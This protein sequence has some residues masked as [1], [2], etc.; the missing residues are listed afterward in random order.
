MTTEKKSDFLWTTVAGLIFVI[1]LVAGYKFK[2]TMLKNIAETAEID[3]SCDLKQG[4]CQSDLPKGGKV[5]LSITPKD[6]PIL[7]PLKLEVIVEGVDATAVAV[8]FVGIDMD[9]GYNRSKLKSVSDSSLFTG[10]AVI[11]VCV[12]SKME[13]EARVLLQTKRGL[14]MVPFRFFTLK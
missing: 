11:P 8:D 14:I 6:I 13:W 4:G 10:K 12:R 5:S 7:R 3:R 9:M 1:L 2:T